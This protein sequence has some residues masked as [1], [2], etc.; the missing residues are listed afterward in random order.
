MQWRK[1]WSIPALINYHCMIWDQYYIIIDHCMTIIVVWSRI[2]IISSLD[3]D[4]RSILCHQRG[5]ADHWYHRSLPLLLAQPLDFLVGDIW[6]C[7]ETAFGFV[8]QNIY[9]SPGFNFPYFRSSPLSISPAAEWHHI[10]LLNCPEKKNHFWRGLHLKQMYE[11][12][13]SRGDKI[14]SFLS[15]WNQNEHFSC[16]CKTKSL[17]GNAHVRRQFWQSSWSLHLFT[18]STSGRK[19]TTGRRLAHQC[20]PW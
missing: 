6:I 11:I 3:D 14:G 8:S 10:F 7:L 2:S 16:F 1:C 19:W 20:P 15:R 4:L 13:F 9:I 5:P 12:L 17:C 18:E